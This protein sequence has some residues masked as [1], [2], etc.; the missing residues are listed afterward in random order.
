[1]QATFRQLLEDGDVDA[2]RRAWHRVAPSMPQPESRED[3][4]IVMHIARTE[5]ETVALRYRA[6]SHRWLTERGLP[7]KL[8][9]DIRPQCERM[10]PQIVETVGIMVEFS[11]PMMSPAAAEVRGAM[12]G[13]V[14]HCFAD[15]K[16]D[17]AFVR[18]RMEQARTDAM[19][20][21]FGR[22]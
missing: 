16:T 17:P 1:M 12:E 10:F 19:R 18:A 20:A 11:D 3:A 7:S 5:A 8:P 4:E 13:A 9:D 2:L 6:Y 15:G 14:N 22:G 21:L